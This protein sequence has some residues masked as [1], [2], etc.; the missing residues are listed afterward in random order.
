MTGTTRT[1]LVAGL[2]ALAVFTGAALATPGT[3]TTTTTT[4]EQAN[5]TASVSMPDQ[6]FEGDT[7]TI[8]SVTLPDGGFAVIYNQS[9]KRIGHT[10]YLNASEHENLTVSLDATVEKPQVLVVT[11]FRNNGSQN[12]SATADKV[13][14][15]DEAGA[16]VTDTSYVYF[17]K[18][19]ER[20]TTEETTADSA[21]EDTT[22]ESE[23]TT[24]ESAM[25]DDTTA[26]TTTDSSGGV[27]GFGVST[28]LVA[29]VAAAFVGLRRR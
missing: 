27:P 8:E 1:V 20:T 7:V 23:Q 2:V 22:A 16:N 14:Y 17:Q 3:T 5:E 26:E 9:G 21:S 18:R 24:D 25:S 19:G 28:A 6:H 10:D 13:P 12:F 15:V 29:L 11:A 4:D